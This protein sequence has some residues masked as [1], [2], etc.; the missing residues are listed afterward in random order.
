MVAKPIPKRSAVEGSG[1][2]AR[3]KYRPDVDSVFVENEEVVKSYTTS[4][5][6]RLAALYAAM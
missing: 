2:S 1:T 3:P 4:S 5:S 6:E